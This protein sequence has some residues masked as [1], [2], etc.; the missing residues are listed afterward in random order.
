MPGH[1]L[2]ICS[3]QRDF[4]PD[5]A[6]AIAGADQLGPV[7]GTLVDDFRRAG[8]PILH[9]VI[10]RSADDPP[11][12]VGEGLVVDGLREGSA[13]HAEIPEAAH[14]HG[15]EIPLRVRSRRSVRE[16]L[17]FAHQ[18]VLVEVPGFDPWEH[19]QLGTV[20]EVI[21]PLRVLLCGLP[22]EL[23]VAAAARGLIR[24]EIPF[25]VLEEAV[26]AREPRRWLEA[27]DELRRMLKF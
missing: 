5:G 2:W 25:E 27:K 13:G 12:E 8:N 3:A 7:L 23:S 20:L 21:A 19:P 10:T 1:L 11:L 14:G 17:D 9:T 24:H 22:G 18:E 16:S 6:L 26:R 15:P 4:L